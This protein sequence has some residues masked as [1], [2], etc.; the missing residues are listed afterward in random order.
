MGTETGATTMANNTEVPQKAK[1][2]VAIWSSNPTPGHIV[3]QNYNSK[4]PMH[5]YTHHSTI[6]SGPDVATT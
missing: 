1:N 2:R 5:P 6:Y 4:N 3:R